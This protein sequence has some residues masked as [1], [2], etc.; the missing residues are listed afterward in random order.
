MGKPKDP[1]VTARDQNIKKTYVDMRKEKKHQYEILNKLA[2]EHPQL[3]IDTI[4]SIISRTKLN[5][6]T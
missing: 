4:A 5:A 6:A 3:D 2:D 1:E